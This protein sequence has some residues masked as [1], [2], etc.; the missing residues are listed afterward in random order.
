MSNI[1]NLDVE[2][3]VR[4]LISEKLDIER[5]DC[6]NPEISTQTDKQQKKPAQQAA[7]PSGLT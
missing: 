5:D 7:E 6:E 2:T 4:L 1:K 3:Y